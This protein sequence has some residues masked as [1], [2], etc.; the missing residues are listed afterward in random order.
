[1]AKRWLAFL[2]GVLAYLIFALAFLYTIGFTGDLLA[3]KPTDGGGQARLASALAIDLGLIALFGV[4]HS[5]MARGAFKQWLLGWVPEPVVRSV[6]VLC[7]SLALFLLYW[8]W[9]PIGITVWDFTSGWPY[10]GL[11][12][13]FWIG[14]GMVAL[15]TCL[16]NHFDLFGLRQVYLYLRSAAYTPVDFQQP[17]AYRYVR[18]PLMF[19]TLVAFWSTPHMSLGHFL[20]AAG[21]SVYIL[22]GVRFEERDL[23]KSYG[24]AYDHYR[25]VVSMLI[26]LP[27][28]EQ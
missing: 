13:L 22:L 9:R 28:R 3:P 14:W 25:Q 10:L 23:L 16:I 6:F 12:A 26:P 20:F 5:L 24:E 11:Q 8:Q 4:Q 17:A 2:F 19:S 21:M 27:R 18:H 15:S 1:M 7:S